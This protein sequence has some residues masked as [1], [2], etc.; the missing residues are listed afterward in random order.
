LIS[1]YFFTSS[2]TLLSLL[3][4]EQSFLLSLQPFFA[5]GHSALASFL[6]VSVV[7]F[8]FLGLSSFTFTAIGVDK[9]LQ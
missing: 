9:Q 2:F 4:P 1:D 8:A 6:V 5:A 3:V 7:A